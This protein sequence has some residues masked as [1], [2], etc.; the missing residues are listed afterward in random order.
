M[1][2]FKV[3]LNKQTDPIEEFTEMLV[4]DASRRIDLK[5]FGFDKLHATTYLNN[6]RWED[7]YEINQSSI[8]GH[9]ESDLY[10]GMSNAQ[11]QVA[12]AR[13]KR[14]SSEA[15]RPSMGFDGRAVPGQMDAEERFGGVIDLGRGSWDSIG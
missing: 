13:A 6:S 14:S 2:S 15:S 1:K 8:T 5:Q 12:E 10:T 7:E 4:S 11:R 3:A 9:S